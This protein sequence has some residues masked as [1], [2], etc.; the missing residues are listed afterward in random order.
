[1]VWFWFW[2]SFWILTLFSIAVASSFSLSIS[3]MAS[4][5]NYMTLGSMPRILWDLGFVLTLCA[6]D[7]KLENFIPINFKRL[8]VFY[9]AGIRSALFSGLLSRQG[10]WKGSCFGNVDAEVVSLGLD[11]MIS[12]LLRHLFS[13]V[14]HIWK[15][16]H[17]Q[18]RSSASACDRLLLGCGPSG[19]DS[20]G[21][22]FSLRS[23]KHFALRLVFQAWHMSA[24]PT[25]SS[26]LFQLDSV[27][28]NIRNFVRSYSSTSLI[29]YKIASTVLVISGSTV[30]DRFLCRSSLVRRL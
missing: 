2:R 11:T 25:C 16:Q 6:S 17:F 30:L 15:V 23:Q 22:R 8:C 3:H 4:G 13:G 5:L 18:E 12:R 10:V 28:P 14:E 7:L 20:H 19:K 29:D 9:V 24:R 27:R 26:S 21:L 1:M